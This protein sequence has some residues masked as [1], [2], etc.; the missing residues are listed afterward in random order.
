MKPSKKSSGSKVKC[1]PGFKKQGSKVGK[2]GKV[3]NNCV[4]K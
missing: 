2:S 4:K 3:V 1:W